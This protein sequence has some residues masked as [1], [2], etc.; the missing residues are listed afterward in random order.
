MRPVIF[1][2]PAP[3][4]NGIAATQNITTVTGGYVTLNGSLTNYPQALNQSGGVR[5]TFPGIQRTIGVFS[6]GNLSAV[7]FYA[8]GLDLRGAVIT[9]SFA[10]ATGGSSSATDAFATAN[11]EFAVVNCLFTTAAAT[12]LF[13]AG[14]GAT[15]CTNWVQTDGFIAP[16][17]VAG[18]VVTGTIAAVTPQSTAGNPNTSSAPTVFNHATGTVT[19]NTQFSYTTPVPWV[20]FVVSTNTA[21]GAG[22]T[23]TYQQSG[24]G[25]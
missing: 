8:S 18:T 15:G 25:A 1:S 13:T 5:A 22:S 11:V 23:L 6:T 12:S 24:N 17:N 10:G 14:T 2:F 4:Y 7:I 19:A 3:A 20:R 21:S 9:A 16:F